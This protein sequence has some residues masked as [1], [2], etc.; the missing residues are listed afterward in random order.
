[1][2]LHGK[3][4]GERYTERLADDK[5]QEDTH[6]DAAESGNHFEYVEIGQVRNLHSGIRK[7]E[8][9]HNKEIHPWTQCVLEPVTHR[10][11]SLRYP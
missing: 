2:K 3:E 11:G 5:T 7:G 9:R 4:T 8:E 10:Y 6:A 1:M